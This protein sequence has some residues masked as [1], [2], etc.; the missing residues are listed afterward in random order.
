VVGM[1]GDTDD[2]R[3]IRRVG[4]GG[5]RAAPHTADL[6]IEAWAPSRE[7]C[8]AE[9]AR[10]LVESFA[11][12]EAV[13]PT[14][15]ERLRLPRA[16]DADLLAALLDEVVYRV[17]VHGQVPVEVEAEAAS[18]GG[19]DVRLGVVPL[20]KVEVTGAAPKA[21]SWHGLHMGV[22]SYGWSCAVTVDV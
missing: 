2:V 19:L 21:V 13:R 11:D 16:D 8:L 1:V 17:E 7:G 22:D 9:A 3:E 4:T 5:H 15:L 10:G 14:A 18:D 20:S 6:R 12:V